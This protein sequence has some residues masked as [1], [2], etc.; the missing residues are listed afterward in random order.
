MS[1]TTMMPI[2]TAISQCPP[3]YLRLSTGVQCYTNEYCSS[4]ATGYTCENNVCCMR[5][6]T[7]GFCPPDQVSINGI[8]YGM[9]SLNEPCAYSQQCAGSC[10]NP[11]DVV[12][13]NLQTQQL[14]NCLNEA[15]SP[16]FVCEYTNAGRYQCCGQYNGNTNYNYGL[17]K[18]YPGTTLPLECK[19]INSCLFVDTPNC[20]YSQRYVI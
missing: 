20:V 9:V 12:E 17:V 8:C 10:R 15:C 2:L 7:N 18:M 3:N 5:T 6:Q 19:A 1:M 14:K 11:S 4:L 13:R 16:G